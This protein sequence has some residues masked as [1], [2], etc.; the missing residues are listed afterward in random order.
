MSKKELD[1]KVVEYIEKHNLDTSWCATVQDFYLCAND[2]AKEAYRKSM[3]NEEIDVTHSDG[4]DCE[5]TVGDR[6]CAC[7]NNRYYLE[8]EGDFIKG[9]YSYGQWC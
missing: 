6:R 4:E 7:G 8:V 5:W 1:T 9:F 2:H 3:E